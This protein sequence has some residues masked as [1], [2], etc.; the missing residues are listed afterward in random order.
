MRPDRPI[1]LALCLLIV[2]AAWL[3]A[4]ADH[5]DR[6]ALISAGAIT[7]L[8]AVI[9][10]LR[11]PTRRTMPE[12]PQPYA[13][14]DEAAEFRKDLFN[15]CAGLKLGIR[16]CEDHLDAEPDDLIERLQQMSDS[17][18]SFV[19]EATR[20]VRFYQRARWTWRVFTR[21]PWR[22]NSEQETPR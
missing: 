19:N 2:G 7:L 6:F 3:A 9:V 22:P 4:R 13:P 20:P 1:T 21:W 11:R 8:C 12:T 18:A 16:F 14:K 10:L 5:F 17:I 15:L